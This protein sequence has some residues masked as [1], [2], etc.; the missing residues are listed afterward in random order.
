MQNGGEHEVSSKEVVRS[1]RRGGKGKDALTPDACTHINSSTEQPK[2]KP[3]NS[4]RVNGFL[5]FK[6][7]WPD[8]NR[9]PL[10]P[11]ASALP[12]CATLRLCPF[13]N[14]GSVGEAL[15]SPRWGVCQAVFMRSCD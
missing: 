6:S 1:P 2:Q 14:R 3:A 5:S 8:L 11:H 13:E 4:L 15:F 7:E 12:S 10:A 9:R